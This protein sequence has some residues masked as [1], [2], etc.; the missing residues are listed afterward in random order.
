MA[1]NGEASLHPQTAF[2]SHIIL[3]LESYSQGFACYGI[4]FSLK[5]C[6]GFP[7]EEQSVDSREH[8]R[9]CHQS[10]WYRQLLHVI[11]GCHAPKGLLAL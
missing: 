2:P 6:R 5:Y 10:H 7:E 4:H 1:N 3:K 9:V 11:I 8:K